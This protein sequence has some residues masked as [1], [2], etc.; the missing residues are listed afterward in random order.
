MQPWLRRTFVGIFGASA[1]MGG[2]AACSSH[3]HGYHGWH[4]ANDE[5]HA[6][7]KARLVEKAASKLELDAAQKA[8]LAVLL[9]RLDEQ[10]AALRGAADPRKEVLSLIDDGTFDRWHAQDLVN[11]RIQAVR[12]KS[13]QVIAAMGEFYD[14]LRPEQQAR[15][16]E[17][18][19]RAGR[20]RHHG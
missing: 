16:R 20:W 15:V 12:D 8:R 11:A 17:F 4:A 5:D 10:R 13:P 9:D 3:T 2:V 6:K 1:L 18:V 7:Y 14:S 19:Q